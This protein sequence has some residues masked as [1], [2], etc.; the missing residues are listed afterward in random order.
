MRLGRSSLSGG[1]K[2]EGTDFTGPVEKGVSRWNEL[3]PLSDG[4]EK[5]KQDQGRRASDGSRSVQ[6]PLEVGTSG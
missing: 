2:N 4:V 3:S 1:R 5:S 6:L